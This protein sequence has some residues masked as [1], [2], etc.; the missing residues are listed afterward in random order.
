MEHKLSSEIPRACSSDALRMPIL[1]A[2]V[3]KKEAERRV[4]A[5]RGGVGCY[6]AST[7]RA[8]VPPVRRTSSLIARLHCAAVFR[9]AP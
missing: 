5:S 9:D 8:Q 2:G 3:Q 4:S 7:Q 6:L 1:P